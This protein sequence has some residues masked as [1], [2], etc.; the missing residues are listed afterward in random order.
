MKKTS[1]TLRLAFYLCIA[2]GL[3]SA[4]FL[5]FAF[6]SSDY[7]LSIHHFTSANAFIIIGSILMVCG[8]IG[9]LVLS[10]LS[11]KKATLTL[12]PLPLA[13]VFFAALS[14]T[15]LLI[16]IY[17]DFSS[18]A[19]ISDTY[20]ANIGKTSAIALYVRGCLA[21]PSG[22]YFFL[23][24]FP[25]L[26]AKAGKLVQAL[27]FFPILW[28]LASLLFSYFNCALA[29]NEPEKTLTILLASGIMLQMLLEA[30]AQLPER[31]NALT[32]FIFLFSTT[33]QTALSCLF[34]AFH[35]SNLFGGKLPFSLSFISSALYFA[36]TLL[37]LTR[38]ITAFKKNN[39][40]EPIS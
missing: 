8:S 36:L 14:A 18:A 21:I 26:T 13:G 28:S 19:N 1:R 34:F 35:L 22:A 38:G 23:I 15:L 33:I 27:S 7:D 39:E 9:A 4:A 24:L 16:S 2:L 31:K 25:A 20:G 6:S 29:I 32:T 17:F 11:R 30:R 37:L 5:F 12:A 10:I 3:L 40:N